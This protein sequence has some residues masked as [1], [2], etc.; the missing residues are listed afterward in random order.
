M[1]KEELYQVIDAIM[2]RAS[3]AE[4]EVIEKALDRRRGEDPTGLFGFEPGRLA[5][6]MASGINDQLAGSRE[7]I[8]KT[9]VEFVE[10]MIRSQAPELS[11]SQIAELTAAWMP[12][13]APPGRAAGK[14]AGKGRVP[15]QQSQSPESNIPPEVLETM[16]QQFVDYSLGLLER[17]QVRSLEKEMGDWTRRYWEHFPYDVRELVS[18]FL[19]GAMEEEDFYLALQELL[20]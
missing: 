14:S 11:E 20:G 5:G 19:K 2:N 8:R 12:R 4:L 3:L 1:Q 15:P 13:S 10:K 7:M 6:E 9:V 16:V 17:S 18:L